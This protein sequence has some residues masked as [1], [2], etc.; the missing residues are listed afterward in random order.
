VEEAY[1]HVRTAISILEVVADW[2]DRHVSRV[3]GDVRR[4]GKH[5]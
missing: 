4:I 5:R 1:D 3:S 2:E